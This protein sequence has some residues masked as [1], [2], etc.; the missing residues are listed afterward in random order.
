MRRT[1]FLLIFL[2][3][4]L[5]TQ[6]QLYSISF[7]VYTGGTAPFSFDEG[8]KKDPRYQGQ[9]KAKFV[10]IGINIGLDYE[11]FGVMASPGLINVGQNF[12]LLN[13]QGGQDGLRK[14][15]L[16]Y[17]TVPLSFRVHLIHFTTFK[18][19][20]LASISP[21]FL[22]AGKEELSHSATK[23]QFPQQVYPILPAGYTVEYDGVLAPELQGYSMAE[24]KDF[25]S[26]QI[27]AGAGFRSDW[28][29]SNHWRI[30]VDLRV[31]YG[32]FDPRTEA[33]TRNEESAPSLYKLAGERRDVFAQFTIGI[34]RYIEIEKS[35]KERKK[36]LKGTTRKYKPTQHPGQ[37]SK[38]SK[39]KG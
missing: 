24:K 15:D 37:R 7:G 23:I 35:E 31:N 20:A 8:I 39:P 27:F 6:A 29:P 32:I 11:T 19:S 33:Y 4:G 2:C 16:R 18:L 30:S 3:W 9:F 1:C 21:S 13:T 17:F 38:Q 25:R 34:S 22:L 28:D 14:I 26:L 10:P 36:K 12:Y 5:V